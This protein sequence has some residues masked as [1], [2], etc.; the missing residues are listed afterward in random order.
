[1]EQRC[2]L[3]LLRAFSKLKA[4]GSNEADARSGNCSREAWSPGQM[5]KRLDLFGKKYLKR[6]DQNHGKRNLGDM[7]CIGDDLDIVGNGKRFEL[8]KGSVDA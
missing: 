3:E 7:G 5:P 1:M 4:S 6:G 8:W 2:Q